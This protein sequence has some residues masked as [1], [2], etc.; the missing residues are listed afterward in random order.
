ME[1]LSEAGFGH[2]RAV[3]WEKPIGQSHVRAKLVRGSPYASIVH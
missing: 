2:G 3:V 1:N